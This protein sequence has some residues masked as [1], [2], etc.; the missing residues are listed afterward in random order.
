MHAARHHGVHAHGITL[1]E[2]QLAWARQRIAQAGLQ[3]R[4]TVELRDYRDVQ[5]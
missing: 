3:D 4:V 5:G 2:R 1:S